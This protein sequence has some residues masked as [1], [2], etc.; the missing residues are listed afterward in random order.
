MQEIISHSVERLAKIAPN[1]YG[2]GSIYETGTNNIFIFVKNKKHAIVA[3]MF[4]EAK[5]YGY[6]SV[7]LE[8]Q[9]ARVKFDE[10]E[11]KFNKFM[12]EQKK[13]EEELEK[14]VEAAKAAEAEKQKKP[15]K[16]KGPVKDDNKGS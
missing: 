10:L 12:D 13:K 8:G 15:T 16:K 1:N 3:G 11:D 4:I 9:D 5:E 6:C 7:L 14:R 2:M